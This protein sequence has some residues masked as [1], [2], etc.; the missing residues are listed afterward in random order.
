MIK[1]KFVCILEILCFFE[2]KPLRSFAL[3]FGV[4]HIFY[5]YCEQFNPICIYKFGFVG[6]SNT[7]VPFEVAS[8][9]MLYGHYD[10][11]VVAFAFFMFLFNG[12]H[13][14]KPST[15]I[16]FKST[17]VNIIRPRNWLIFVESTENIHSSWR[18][19]STHTWWEGEGSGRSEHTNLR[20][21]KL[22]LSSAKTSTSIYVCI[23]LSLLL[24][25]SPFSCNCQY[26]FRYFRLLV[27]LGRCIPFCVSSF[28]SFWIRNKKKIEIKKEI[29]LKFV[30]L[31]RIRLWIQLR[32]NSY[33]DKGNITSEIN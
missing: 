16:T 25:L 20:P 8:I 12:I 14:Q 19:Q 11:F 3:K 33:T 24:W 29:R 31:F 22:L 18:E 9:S 21:K 1:R 6:A 27:L 10:C 5:R 26:L 17:T 32:P 4:I 23:F 7:I 30:L 28:T 2:N 15:K 13:Y